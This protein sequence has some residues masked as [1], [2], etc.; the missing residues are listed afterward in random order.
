MR[1]SFE[2]TC[3]YC[4]FTGIYPIPKLRD[5]SLRLEKLKLAVL[6]LMNMNSTLYRHLYSSVFDLPEYEKVN[7]LHNSRVR[8]LN[9]T[10]HDKTY[11]IACAPSEHSD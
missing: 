4:L 3:I 11:K 8:F 6:T 10:A 5:F 9:D 1:K 7:I 2:S